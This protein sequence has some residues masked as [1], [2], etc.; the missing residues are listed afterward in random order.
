MAE[1]TYALKLPKPMT[2]PISWLSVAYESTHSPLG[3]LATA[4]CL[5]H[6]PDGKLY[7]SAINDKPL[8][9]RIQIEGVV[10]H[11]QPWMK[12]DTKYTIGWSPTYTPANAIIRSLP[13]EKGKEVGEI[14]FV[15]D[16]ALPEDCKEGSA[17]SRL[18]EKYI[19]RME[20]ILVRKFKRL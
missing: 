1:K 10:V 5:G 9:A 16:S 14:L 11:P 2:N 17:E 19:R 3:K 8:E 18:I 15:R 7:L 13:I 20:R 12:T 4:L 6:L